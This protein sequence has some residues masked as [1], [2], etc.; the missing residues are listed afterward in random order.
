MGS[1]GREGLNMTAQQ[2]KDLGYNPAAIEIILQI[3][4]EGQEGL[5]GR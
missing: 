3:I 1:Q 4:V 2:L 5:K